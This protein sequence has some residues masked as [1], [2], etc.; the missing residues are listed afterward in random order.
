MLRIKSIM[1]MLHGSILKRSLAG[2]SRYAAFWWSP[3]GNKL[4]YLR[5]DETDVPVFTLN[6]LDE[7]DGL[8]G[9]Y[10]S[11]SLSAAGRSESKGKNGHCRYWNRK[12]Y[13]GKNRL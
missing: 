2:R 4:A 3:D 5:T 1:V 8:H 11:C 10:R 7:A 12:N 13:L 6:R 9:L